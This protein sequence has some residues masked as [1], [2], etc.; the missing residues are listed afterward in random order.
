MKVFKYRFWCVTEEAYVYVWRSE[1]EST[2]TLCPNNSAH[3]VD[4]SNLTIVETVEEQDV[5]IAGVEAGVILPEQTMGVPDRSGYNVF[6]KGYEFVADPAAPGGVTEHEAGYSQ[7]MLLQGLGFRVN[8]D[9]YEG[10]DTNEGDYMEVEMVDVNGVTGYPPG[11]VLAKFAETIPV[12]PDRHFECVC[13]D[14]KSLPPTVAIRLR[15]VARGAQKVRIKL[16]H[17]MRTMPQP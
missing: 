10:D 14:A 9:A 8:S 7:W 5:H 16:E 4:L 11:T 6:R 17:A 1:N 12:W 2:P 15:Y 3:T 13:E